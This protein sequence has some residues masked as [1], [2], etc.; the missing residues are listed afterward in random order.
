MSIKPGIGHGF[1]QRWLLDRISVA[2]GRAVYWSKLFTPVFSLLYPTVLSGSESG[3]P[4][5]S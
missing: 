4:E 2:R 5:H 3:E 1:R